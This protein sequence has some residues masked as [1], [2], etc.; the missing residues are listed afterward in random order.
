M[1][2]TLSRISEIVADILGLEP[3]DL[4]AASGVD[5]TDGWDSIQHLA[6]MM[7]V[8]AEFSTRFT[9]GQL[10]DAQTMGAIVGLIDGP[11]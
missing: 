2:D 1:S 4:D 10:A 9:P 7:D 3:E 5:V 8:E 11:A 6:I